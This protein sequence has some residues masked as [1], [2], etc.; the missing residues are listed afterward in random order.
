MDHQVWPSWRYILLLPGLHC[1]YI[2]R[3]IFFC[4]TFID[5]W[6]N[7]LFLYL[8]TCAFLLEGRSYHAD[9]KYNVWTWK[10][11]VLSWTYEVR[12]LICQIY[13]NRSCVC[14]VFAV[15]EKCWF[16]TWY[17]TAP[18]VTVPSEDYKGED[19]LFCNF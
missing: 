13:L 3:F 11:D 17:R 18:N 2:F 5:N 19:N 15:W 10:T 9:V 7:K 12:L 6:L 16:T 14:I 1:R 8:I 4:L